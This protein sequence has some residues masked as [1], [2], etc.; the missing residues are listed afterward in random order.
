MVYTHPAQYF[1]LIFP[2]FFLENE[3]VVPN[4]ISEIHNM[5]PDQLVLQMMRATNP[6]S[7]TK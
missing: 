4:Y 6:P 1:F 7:K 5:F 2:D 3:G